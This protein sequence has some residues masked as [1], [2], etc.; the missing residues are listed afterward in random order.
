MRKRHNTLND[1]IFRN[2]KYIDVVNRITNCD[3]RKEYKEQYDFMLDTFSTLIS[4]N[5][6]FFSD[7]NLSKQ[8]KIENAITII[9]KYL[10]LNLDE[11]ENKKYSVRFIQKICEKHSTHLYRRINDWYEILVIPN[12]NVDIVLEEIENEID[13]IDNVS[14]DNVVKEGLNYQKNKDNDFKIF[15]SKFSDLYINHEDFLNNFIDEYN[16]EHKDK[17]TDEEIHN[18]STVYEALAKAN[19]GVMNL[20]YNTV[21]KD[22]EININTNPQ[23][24]YKM[25]LETLGIT[26]H[27]PFFR[28]DAVIFMMET[29]SVYKNV[30]AKK[31]MSFEE[32]INNYEMF[33]FIHLMEYYIMEKDFKINDSKIE[34]IV[35][36]LKQVYNIMNSSRSTEDVV[37]N[38]KKCNEIIQNRIKKN[39]DYFIRVS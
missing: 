35:E 14:F 39:Q 13:K 2:S 11:T 9:E 30:C 20:V 34:N 17:L 38:A 26:I 21:M 27:N 5:N 37:N 36:E 25:Y 15:I 4:L 10:Y 12:N 3:F 31:G 23:E 19:N 22:F 16:D 1:N 6:C 33:S 24:I 32:M 18:I 29:L 8:D 28:M 7:S